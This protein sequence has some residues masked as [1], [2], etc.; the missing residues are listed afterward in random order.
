MYAIVYLDLSQGRIRLDRAI[1]DM[2]LLQG[3][4][5]STELDLDIYYKADESLKQTLSEWNAT[6]FQD[7]I[8]EKI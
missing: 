1:S 4:R 3:V 2:V 5:S 8:Y 6:C 7:R